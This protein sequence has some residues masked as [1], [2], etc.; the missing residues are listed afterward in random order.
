M[1]KS[2]QQLPS[3][4][5]SADD[6]IDQHKQRLNW[7]PWLYYS[8]K[9]KQLIWAKPWQQQLQ[10]RLQ[11]LETVQLGEQ[12]FIADSAQ[13]FAEPGRTIRIG[14]GCMIAADSFLH[15]PIEL[16]ARVSINHGCSLDGGAAGVRIGDDTRIANSVK[17][18]GF[19]HGMAPDRAVWQQPVT[20]QG[21][22]IGCDV[23][24]GAGVGIVDGV[25]IGDHAVIGM[26]S[27]VTKDVPDYAIVAGNP[28]RIIGDR[29]DK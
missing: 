6:Y 29:R 7:M 14:N 19:N 8:L 25:T 2:D 5:P 3:W 23:W 4:Q 15:G 9:P 1:P 21:I 24:V 18:Y 16:G 27:V 22:S 13:L 17:I 20:S 10:Q 12:C 11:A 28:A 26:G